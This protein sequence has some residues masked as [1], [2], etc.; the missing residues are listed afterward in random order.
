M[1]SC[2][3]ADR[4]LKH[5][6]NVWEHAFN[7]D[8]PFLAIIKQFLKV[9][10]QVFAVLSILLRRDRCEKKAPASTLADNNLTH[11]SLL[12]KPMGLVVLPGHAL[13]SENTFVR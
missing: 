1:D 4:K 11:S 3:C 12:Q 6:I 7:Q 9:S 2:G 8:D 5:P 10:Q 13:Q